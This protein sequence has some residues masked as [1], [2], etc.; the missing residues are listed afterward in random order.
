M[1]QENEKA[2]PTP[3]TINNDETTERMMTASRTTNEENVNHADGG[4]RT[5]KA[6]TEIQYRPTAA[7]TP[8][9]A[10][11]MGRYGR[12]VVVVAAGYEEGGTSKGSGGSSSSR[13]SSF[14]H[15]GSV[16]GPFFCLGQ[17]GKGT[18]SSIH[19]CIHM[20]YYHKTSANSND[21][22]DSIRKAP[23]N[24]NTVDAAANAKQHRRRRLAAAKVELSTFQQSGVLE[25]ESIMLDFLHRTI[26]PTSSVPIYMGHYRSSSSASSL[27][28][29][30]NNNREFAAALVMEYLVGQDMHQMREDVMQQAAA[31]ANASINTTTRR[32]NVVDA[33]YFT[34]DVMLP[35]LRNMHNVGVVHRDVKPSNCVRQDYS[36]SRDFCLVDF[37]LSKSIVV[38]ETSELANPE[39]P[40][41]EHKPWLEQYPP[42]AATTAASSMTTTEDNPP[43]RTTTA[44]GCFR[45][46]RSKADFRGTSMYAS[47]RVHQEMDYCPRD[48]VWS[49]LYVFCDL[50]SGGLPW[51]SHAANRNRDECKALK[52]WVHGDKA[53]SI[54]SGENDDNDGG[55]AVTAIDHTEELLK[56]DIYH[57]AKYRR[58][59][60]IEDKVD[61][62]KLTL[63]PEPLTLSA[64]SVLVD[65]L[66]AAFQHLGQLK[67]WDTPDYDLVQNCIH[68]FLQDTS[69]GPKDPPISSIDWTQKPAFKSVV[70]SRKADHPRM[71]DWHLELEDDD[72]PL[73][74][75][76]FEEAEAESLLENPRK[77]VDGPF[78]DRLP[79]SM[80]Y[81]LAQMDCNLAAHAQDKTAVPPH[82]ALRDWMVVVIP[83]LY[84]EWDSRKYEDG[85]HRTTTDGYK[86]M[87]FLVLLR[88]CQ[89]YAKAFGNFVSPDCF[90]KSCSPA[91]DAVDSADATSGAR[92][93]RRVAV[94]RRSRSST[95]FG[96]KSKSSSNSGGGDLIWVAK[97]LFGLGLAISAEMAKKAPPPVRIS[98]G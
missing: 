73:D 28:N 54:M 32:L 83:L 45:V 88:K 60:Q 46:E 15:P 17:L 92:K 7:T 65:K 30:N 69:S 25:S 44:R 61:P 41:D 40:W 76:I 20:Q 95:A 59:R 11:A 1:N 77:L 79:I 4:G 13:V 18:F 98:F 2:V 72:S 37:G 49:L 63:V 34:A 74:Y 91:D 62:A 68:S 38:P 80:R 86:R 35:L 90:Y 56:G 93:R 53:V 64:N 16:L 9:A 57:L 10:M 36:S 22:D 96:N 70:G 85:G 50:V 19:K 58:D 21:N 82:I 87:H 42:A 51:M 84:D 12:P 67:F 43:S 81:Q 6:A 14:P 27:S 47:L 66:R 71:S 24:S 78:W 31:A 26:A 89:A 52:E 3:V 55:A 29:N 75:E 94:G 39:Q 33:V 48:D 5:S 23:T 97:A 8:D